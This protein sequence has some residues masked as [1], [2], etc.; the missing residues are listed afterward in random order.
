MN[1]TAD[2]LVRST[3]IQM[4]AWL[5]EDASR[6]A[7]QRMLADYQLRCD[8]DE[9]LSASVLGHFHAD[10]EPVPN[11]DYLPERTIFSRCNWVGGCDTE[12]SEQDGSLLCTFHRAPDG[13]VA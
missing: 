4:R 6:S 8:L 9:D 2:S 13:W 3:V 10:A 5:G 12:L 7:A 11:V 1:A